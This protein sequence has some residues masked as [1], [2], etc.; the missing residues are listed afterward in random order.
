MRRFGLIGY[1]LS[2]SFS[3]TYFAEKFSRENITDAVYD[4]FSIP[5]IDELTNILEQHPDLE[6]LNVTIPYKE[7]VIPFLAEKEP[8]VAA[9]G[10]CNC[11]KKIAPGKFKGYNTDTVGFKTSLSEFL[12]PQHDRALILGTGGAA[13]AVE[14]VLNTLGIQYQYV[15]RT[16]SPNRLAYAQISE[17][18]IKETRLIINTTPLGMYPNVDAAPELPYHFLT[19]A[20]YLFDLVYNP[21]KTLFLAK[22]EEQGATIKNGWDM[23]VIQ[24]EESWKIWNS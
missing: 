23:L 15:S 3:K 20:H 4:N 14:Y 8:V 5:A 9:M 19:P 21:A 17:S 6:G 18:L 16:S 12:K 7:L 11:L 22:G 1:P 2:H 24:A 13:K 10:A